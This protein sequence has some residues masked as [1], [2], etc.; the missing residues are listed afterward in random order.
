MT[1]IKVYSK[2]HV[3]ERKRKKPREIRESVREKEMGGAEFFETKLIL[4]VTILK[5]NRCN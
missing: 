1:K 4:K 3:G 2:S 5:T